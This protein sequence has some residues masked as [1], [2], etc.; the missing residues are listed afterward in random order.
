MLCGAAWLIGAE[1]LRVGSVRRA[2]AV[3]DPADLAGALRRFRRRLKGTLLLLLLY[4]LAAFYQRIAM[5]GNFGLRQVLLYTGLVLVVL[6]WLLIIAARDAHAATLEA[7][8]ESKRLRAE[9]IAS[10]ER[11][12]QE[13][14]ENRPPRPPRA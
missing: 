4:V 11:L 1:T 9:A 12:A 10:A 3:E 7:V 2:S 14:A 6:F 5:L 8:A 13:A